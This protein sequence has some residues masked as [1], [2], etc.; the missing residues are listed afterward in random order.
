MSSTLFL[1]RC[2]E[3][4]DAAERGPCPTTFEVNVTG[5]C[6]HGDVC[7]RSIPCRGFTLSELDRFFIV[8]ALLARHPKPDP[9]LI[10]RL[11]LTP[12]ETAARAAYVESL[13]E[14][15]P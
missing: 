1:C 3:Y 15:T 13:K 9:S 12:E 14:K 10:E 4:H 5:A 2:G 6:E 11:S 8:A 7:D